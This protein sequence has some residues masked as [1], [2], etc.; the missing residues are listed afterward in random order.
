VPFHNPSRNGTRERLI[1][2]DPPR[3]ISVF[4]KESGIC[5]LFRWAESD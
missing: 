5:N 3:A 2:Q 1:F 4:Q